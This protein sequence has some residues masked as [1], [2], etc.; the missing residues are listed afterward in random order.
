MTRDFIEIS[1]LTY[2]KMEIGKVVTQ[3]VKIIRTLTHLNPKLSGVSKERGYG[4]MTKKERKCGE[5]SRL[6]EG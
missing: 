4:V 3:P 5:K 2:R 6:R 1:D